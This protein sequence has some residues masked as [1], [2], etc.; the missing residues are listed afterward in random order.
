MQYSR[1]TRHSENDNFS[2]SHG[3]HR[4]ALSLVANCTLNRSYHL[5]SGHLAVD[6]CC[7]E[8]TGFFEVFNIET[9]LFDDVSS[10]LEDIGSKISVRRYVL[11]LD[12]DNKVA[13]VLLTVYSTELEIQMFL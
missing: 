2:N 1:Q 6:L 12:L 10:I 13:S 7:Y 3:A 9:M 4:H 11:P 8:S 5:P